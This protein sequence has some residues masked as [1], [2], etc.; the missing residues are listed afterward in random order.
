MQ[1]VSFLGYL[2]EGANKRYTYCFV[3]S[4]K[5]GGGDRKDGEKQH[6][7]YVEIRSLCGMAKSNFVVRGPVYRHHEFQE[8]A[9]SRLICRGLG[10]NCVVQS[11]M[12]KSLHGEGCKR[13]QTLFMRKKC[14][15]TTS[16]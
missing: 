1:D 13:S 11:H 3:C 9:E 4:T 16:V 14:N 6:R 15:A 5:A 12:Q 2:E 8:D 10:V 7:A